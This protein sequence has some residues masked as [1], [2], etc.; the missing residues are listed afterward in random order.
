MAR[1]RC[2]LPQSER[3]FKRGLY[4]L[5]P[6][7]ADTQ[8][9]LARVTPLLPFTIWLQY[10]NKT[11]PRALQRQQLQA[12]R[13]LCAKAKVPL[14]VNDD[15]RL[16]AEL[17]LS[18]A[19][20]GADDGDLTEA[21]AALGP[22]AL[23]GASCYDDIERAYTAIRAGASY[24]AFGAFFPSTTKP[25]ARRASPQLLRETAALDVPRVAIGGITPENGQ[26]LVDAGADL[27]AIISGVFDA[28][29][30]AAAARRYRA[31]FAPA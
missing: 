13:P 31:C 11:A 9:L 18:G 2:S 7:I 3:G 24:I 29:D 4:L 8:T 17:G 5:T 25:K 16:A 12:L 20:L 19:H 21:R 27:L 10:R 14:L 30:P 26:A 6:D 1:K 22:D 28:P 23:L 15:W